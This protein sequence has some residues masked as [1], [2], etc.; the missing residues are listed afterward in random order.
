MRLVQMFIGSIVYP[1]HPPDDWSNIVKPNSVCPQY[2]LFTVGM[3]FENFT[4]FQ[5]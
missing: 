1:D 4:T 5:I 3:I 2:F